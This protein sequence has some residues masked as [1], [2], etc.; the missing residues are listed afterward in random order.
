[1]LNFRDM[2]EIVDQKVRK[3]RRL[4]TNHVRLRQRDSD[5]VKAIMGDHNIVKGVNY[6]KTSY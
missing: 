3:V 5:H 4:E 6:D 2:T 1:M